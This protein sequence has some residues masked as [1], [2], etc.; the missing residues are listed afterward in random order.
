MWIGVNKTDWAD[1]AYFAKTK[2]PSIYTQIS[3]AILRK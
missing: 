1:V 3:I 2:Q